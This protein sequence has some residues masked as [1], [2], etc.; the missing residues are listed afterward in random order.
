VP[1]DLRQAGLRRR[2]GDGGAPQRVPG[3]QPQPGLQ[4]PAARVAGVG[5]HGGVVDGHD[6]R[7]GADQRGE[8]GVRGVQHGRAGPADEAG[9]FPAPVGGADGDAGADD[10]GVRRQFGQRE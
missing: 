10:L 3:Q 4:V 6:E 5:L 8:H 2:G 9:Q 7:A 1:H